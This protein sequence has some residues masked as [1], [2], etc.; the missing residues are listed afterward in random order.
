MAPTK[1]AI[2]CSW[3]VGI[4]D[5]TPLEDNTTSRAIH[6]TWNVGIEQVDPLMR[7]IHG[8]WNVGIES[9]DP[10]LR[11]IYATWA[12]DLLLGPLTNLEWILFDTDFKTI[13]HILRGK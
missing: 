1:R 8:T 10:L 5:V 9:V 6:G 11:A 2:Y 4:E 3:N 13:E 7:V 12:V